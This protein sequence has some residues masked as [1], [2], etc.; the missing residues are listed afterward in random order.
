MGGKKRL[1]EDAV[2]AVTAIPKENQ[3]HN[4]YKS[5]GLV[6]FRGII[7]SKKRLGY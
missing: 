5:W 3:G 6:F 1:N 4:G 2:S 7:N